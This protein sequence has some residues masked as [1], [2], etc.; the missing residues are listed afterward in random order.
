[1]IKYIKLILCI[2]AF[3]FLYFIGGDWVTTQPFIAG[4]EYFLI[5][6][7]FAVCMFY[8]IL[9]GLI[10]INFVRGGITGKECVITG[11]ILLFFALGELISFLLTKFLV[12]DFITQ[13]AT[14]LTGGAVCFQ[15]I[16][17]M[18]IIFA[19]TAKVRS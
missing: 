17:G 9:F 10:L 2:A 15:I 7:K 11:L 12:F 13:V 3:L 4:N 5:L 1:M 14:V 19:I 8:G 6:S 18:W 16:F